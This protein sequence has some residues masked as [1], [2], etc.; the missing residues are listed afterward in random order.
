MRGLG[1]RLW[2]MAARRE[3]SRTD[4]WMDRT[5]PV[6]FRRT[7]GW[8]V[9]AA[10]ALLYGGVGLALPLSMHWRLL[11]LVEANVLAS[12]FSALIAFIWFVVQMEG[13]VRRHLV[14]WTTELRHLDA[15][16]F[17][18]LVGE[19]FR[20][21]GWRVTETGS[22]DGPD[23]NVDLD[24]VREGQ[25][26]IVQCKRWSAQLVG[27]DEVRKL[28]GTLLREGL[29]GKAGVLVTLAGFTEQALA[30]GEKSG[31]TLVDG[32]QLY[33]KVERVRRPEPC[34]VCDRPMVLG[35]SERG[36]WFRCV[37]SGCNGKR[38][39]SADP[40]KA[41]DILLDKA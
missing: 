15:R 21:E 14:E 10:V 20:R 11:F 31:M 30:E 32:R 26:K 1:A 9:A 2:C 8:L 39:L 27:V 3:R 41:V 18:W 16:E 24:M 25:R 38:D 29:P 12:L 35:R 19:V 17:E 4:L 6:I 36:W 34:P 37:A 7:P 33:A 40:G 5:L 28:G 23:G 13:A 22:Q